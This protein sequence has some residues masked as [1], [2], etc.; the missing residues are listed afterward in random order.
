MV[1]FFEIMSFTP[2]L[3]TFFPRKNYVYSY[4][5]ETGVTGL[6]MLRAIKWH[7]EF[8]QTKGALKKA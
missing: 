7:V 5:Y 3:N 2:M 8:I 4:R 6:H 1:S